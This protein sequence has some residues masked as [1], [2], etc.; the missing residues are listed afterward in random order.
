MRNLF[1]S[2]QPYLMSES[3]IR[4]IAIEQGAKYIGHEMYPKIYDGTFAIRFF[5][6]D[7]KE[8]LG[9]VTDMNSWQDFRKS[10]REWSEANLSRINLRKL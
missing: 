2:P 4:E 5:N 9:H 6:E 8:I 1:F 7:K 3:K 10:P